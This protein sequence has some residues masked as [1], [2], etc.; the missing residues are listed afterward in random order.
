MTNPRSLLALSIAIGFH[1]SGMA[2]QS[3]NS[4]PSLFELSL[5]ELSQLEVTGAA[6]RT[7]GFDVI[8]ETGNPTKRSN[9]QLAATVEIFDDNTIKARGLKNVVEVVEGMVGVLSG[10]SP[11][12]PYSFSM[13]GFTRDSVAV[14]YDGISLGRAT[15][16]TR[17]HTTNNIDRVEVVKGRAVLLH[18]QGTAGGTVNLIT[19]KARLTQTHSQEMM[20]S[21]GSNATYSVNAGMAGPIADEIAYRLDASLRQSDGWVDESES[22]YTD[23]SAS[24]LW[25]PQKQFNILLSASYLQDELPAYWGTPLVPRDVARR[26]ASGVVNTADGLV[27]DKATREINYNVADREIESD[28]LWLRSDIH[29]QVNDQVESNTVLH[30]F[31]ADREWRNAESYIYDRDSDLVIRDRLLVEHD[32]EL[33]GI[34]SGLLIQ[35]NLAKKANRFSVNVEYSENDFKRWVGF[36]PINF[37]VDAVDLYH[38]VA[39]E[40][41]EVSNRFGSV[42]VE[43]KALI[44][45]NSL[46]LTPKL[47]WDIGWRYEQIDVDREYFNFDGSVIARSTIANEYDENSYNIGFVYQLTDHIN[48]FAQYSKQHDR[49]EADYEFSYQVSNFKPSDINQKEIGLKALLNNERVELTLALYEIEK[50]VTAQRSDLSF[51]NNLQQSKGVELAVSSKLFNDVSLG[52][53]IAYT[54][55]EFGDY[56]DPDYGVDVPG[57][58][59]VNVPDLM[60]S[61]WG[62][63]SQVANLPLEIGIGINHVSDRYANIENSIKLKSYTLLNLFASYTHNNYRYALHIRNATDEIYAPWSDIFYPGQVALGAPRT[64]E[65]SVQANY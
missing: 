22:K 32:R 7:L 3:N 17:P 8:P 44:A 23:I 50:R 59:P 35:S 27:I 38:P 56:Y 2:C 10:E 18:G 33:W 5:G 20:T 30:H 31:H 26:P 58:T 34:K 1:N 52:G 28:S 39:G 53:N 45:N 36:E 55:A 61:T 65:L 4:D 47:Q 11:S 12:E 54:D 43:T 16:N 9:C 15:M 62:S 63:V 24:T 46:S 60:I 40:F 49:I 13:R 64:I 48:A 51:E 37:F 21:F 42:L 25:Q 19:K 41:G 57:N 14:L 6:V 29:W